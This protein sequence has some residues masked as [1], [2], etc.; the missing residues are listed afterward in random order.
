MTRVTKS[1]QGRR[2]K[3]FESLEWPVIQPDWV[4]VGVVLS[5]AVCS[6][7]GASGSLCTGNDGEKDARSDAQRSCPVARNAVIPQV[8]EC[9]AFD[10]IRKALSLAYYCEKDTAEA[11]T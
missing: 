11:V 2:F 10:F 7:S 6:A 3:E 1:E 8:H 5:R 9:D 4:V